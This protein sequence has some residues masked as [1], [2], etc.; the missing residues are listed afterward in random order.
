M[1]VRSNVR[2]VDAAALQSRVRTSA[3][4]V[5]NAEAVEKTVEDM[6]IEAARQGYSFVGVRPRA[7]RN[8][9]NRTVSLVY[10]VEEGARLYIEQI[11]IRGN[12]RTRDYVIRREFDVAEGD[13]YNRALINRAERRLKNLNFFKTVKITSEPGSAPDRVIVNVDVE[14]QPTGEFSVA[15]GFSTADGF[16]GEV[17]LG[18][19]NL[20][21]RGQYAKASVQY[22]Q[23]STGF[24]LS[25]VEPYLLGY[26]LALGLDAFVEDATCL[27]LRVLRHADS[28]RQRP[29]RLRAARRSLVADAL[30]DLPAGNRRCPAICATVTT[31]RS[32]HSALPTSNP[33]ARML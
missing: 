4:N 10:V 14:D 13:A 1:E 26:R 3:G 16:M 17:S 19:R 30:L 9:D 8:H 23:Y 7:D 33:T 27:Q 15:G 28:R 6:T 25:F 22:G 29:V 32:I 11:N 2:A 12:T 18:E 31:I 20:L 21:G 24:Q 5:Y